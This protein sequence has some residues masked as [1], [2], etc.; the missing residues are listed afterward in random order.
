[1]NGFRL[2]HHVLITWDT[3]SETSGAHLPSSR[4]HN[5]AR[6]EVGDNI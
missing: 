2:A 3:H 6:D 5:L 1:M 4:A